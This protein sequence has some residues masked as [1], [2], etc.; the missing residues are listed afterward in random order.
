MTVLMALLL[1]LLQAAG[2]ATTCSWGPAREIGTLP[3]V[4]NESSGLAI[5]RRIPNRSYNTNDS[6][7][8]GRFFVLDLDGRN[9]RMVTIAG[10]VP[11]D[12]EDLAIG[13]CGDSSDC[14]FIADTGDNNRRR[15]YVELLVVK[16][17]AEFPGTVEPFLRVRMR[18]PD[19][20]HD[21]EAV[22]VHPDGTLYIT[23]KSS[24]GSK[25]FRLPP[26]RWRNSTNPVETLEPVFSFD[27]RR[28]NP[29]PGDRDGALL[30]TAMDIA[31]DG[32]RFLL[33][34]YREATE[35]YF[36]LS[37]AIPNP[38]TWREG[39]EFRR[40]RVTELPQQE[41]IAYLPDGRSFLYDTERARVAP[42]A[43]IMR[44]DCR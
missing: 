14:L 8:T 15:P 27:W 13:P 21:A 42:V 9:E 6:G 40:I 23:T 32:R 1:S 39:R 19:G 7:D 35:F 25:I 44:V 30:A 31:P 16:E 29:I 33:L 20:P 2:P 28:V 18:Y 34:T 38:A 36:D 41:A 5:S 24:S 43:P 37:G 10:F 3:A 11:V 4:L 17:M 26:A 12:V 22:S